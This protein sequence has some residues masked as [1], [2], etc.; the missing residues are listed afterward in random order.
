MDYFV[1]NFYGCT[2]EN[3]KSP[4][5][6]VFTKEDGRLEVIKVCE[7]VIT[8]NYVLQGSNTQG[9]TVM[10]TKF[11]QGEAAMM[12]TGAWVA[13][14]MRSVGK[15]DD[16]T[17]MKTPVISSITDKLTTVK[18]EKDLRTVISAVD[19]VTDGKKDLAEY[20]DGDNYLIDGL[21]VSAVDWEYIR[22]ARNTEPT[23][24]AGESMF[25]PKYSNAKEGA[26]E[27]V[28]FLYSDEG[29][30]VYADTL[31]ITLPTALDSGELD[32]SDWNSFEKTM[33]KLSNSM[34]Q[35]ATSYLKSKHPIFWVG[36]AA[37]YGASGVFGKFCANNEKD[38]LNAET[39]WKQVLKEIDT[40]YET[41]WVANLGE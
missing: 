24:F 5:K 4:S 8:P 11:L 13:N 7:K 2:D 29:Y 3:G 28:K 1:N 20:Q 21:S 27:F 40:Y 30:K 14:E 9:I 34:E 25:I 10:Q 31:H 39:A 19:A 15:M 22:K 35:N 6:D 16:F 26:K 18:K 32:T 41:S 37:E 36:G 23:N 38:R 17:V 33:Y 12:V